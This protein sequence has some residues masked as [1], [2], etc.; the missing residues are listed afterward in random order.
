M[1]KQS[2]ENVQRAT[3]RILPKLFTM[4]CDAKLIADLY[5]FSDQD[6]T[7]MPDKLERAVEYFLDSNK[8]QLPIAYG[9]R[10]QIVDKKLSTLNLSPE[11]SLPR[12]FSNALV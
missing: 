10:T 7:W 4:A 6:D 3:T 11:F 1:G 2:I 9:S 8:S 12:S 5:A